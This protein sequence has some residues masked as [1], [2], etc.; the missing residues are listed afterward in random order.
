MQR[1]VAW[2][3][4]LYALLLMVFFLLLGTVLLRLFRVSLSM[5][6]IVGGIILTRIGFQLFASSPSANMVS[7][8]A[9]ATQTEKGLLSSLWPCQSCSDR[10]HRDACRNGSDDAPM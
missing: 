9:K 7:Q 5:V 2:K 6:Q 3:S 8:V 4:C 1:R 10:G